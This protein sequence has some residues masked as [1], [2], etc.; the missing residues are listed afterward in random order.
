MYFELLGG[1]ENV[2]VCTGDGG[3][4]LVCPIPDEP[5]RYYMVGI[6]AWGIACNNN[7]IPGVYMDVLKYKNWI[8]DELIKANVDINTRSVG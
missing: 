2:D 4:P 7:G 5:D 1:E 8:I 6:V 3:S